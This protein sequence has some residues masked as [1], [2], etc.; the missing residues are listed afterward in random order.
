MVPF[1][2][3]D[4]PVQYASVQ[5]EHLAVREKAG[6]FDVSHMG[7]FEFSG[8]NVHLFLNTIATNDVSL[9]APGESQYSFLLAEDGAV[10]D[11]IWVYRVD[12]QRYWMVVNAANNDKDF[13]WIDAVRRAVV[14]IDPQR[15]WARALGTETVQMRDLRDPA[16]GADMRA[17]LALQGPRSLD[18]LLSMLGPDN[19][20]ADRVASMERN[21]II[22]LQLAGFDLYVSRTGYT[23]EPVAY[24]IFAHPDR[25]ADL[26][27]A[28]LRAGQPFGLRP[29]GLAA[30]DSLRTEA[31][32]PLYGHELAGPLG[33]NPADAGFAPYVKLYKPFFIGKRAYLTHERARHSRLV[34]FRVEDERAPM[35]GPEDVIVNRKG[36]VVGA[37]TSCS[38]DSD[39]RLT[40]LGY[41]QEPNHERDTQLSVFRLGD[42]N[43]ETHQLDELKPGDRLQLPLDIT[44]IARFLNKKA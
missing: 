28:L 41:V 14:Q 8:D 42:R 12:R 26:W 17:Q 37:V 43:W 16:V 7:L 3:W 29:I 21:Q 34:R 5:E 24:E 18:I 30:R 27:E 31:G 1:A 44:V 4:M 20:E 33:L 11:D 36:R 19:P 9:I 23:G 15:P 13:A 35:P 38:I 2:G 25:L 22:Q 39:G 10:V 6:L 32:L 40:G